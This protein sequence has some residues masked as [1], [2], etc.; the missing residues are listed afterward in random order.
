KAD[1]VGRSGAVQAEVLVADVEHAGAGEA[2]RAD[3]VGGGVVAGS[4]CADVFLSGG[5]FMSDGEI[6]GGD[7][8]EVE[9]CGRGSAADGGRT[10]WTDEH[11]SRR[12]NAAGLIEHAIVV[13]DDSTSRESAPGEVDAPAAAGLGRDKKG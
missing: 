12:R 1:R 5:A 11:R 10:T 2:H 6:V 3:G 7:A 13:D 8:V 4:R 9:L